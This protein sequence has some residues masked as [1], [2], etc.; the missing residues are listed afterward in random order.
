MKPEN[1][2]ASMKSIEEFCGYSARKTRRTA[3][4][5]WSPPNI[6]LKMK[7]EGVKKI[8]AILARTNP[9]LQAFRPETIIDDSLI[10]KIHVSGY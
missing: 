7:P 1:K 8:H 6:D 5:L 3:T 4:T 9:K 10:Q 2:S